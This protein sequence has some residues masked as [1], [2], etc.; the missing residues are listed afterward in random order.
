MKERMKQKWK[1]KERRDK[2]KINRRLCAGTDICLHEEDILT[3][4]MAYGKQDINLQ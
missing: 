1:E 3:V 4:H 2:G